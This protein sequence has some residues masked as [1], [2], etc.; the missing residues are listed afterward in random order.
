MLP[1]RE[2]FLG[3]FYNVIVCYGD[4]FF[5]SYNSLFGCDFS[6]AVIN[7]QVANRAGISIGIE[8]VRTIHDNIASND[9]PCLRNDTNDLGVNQCF[10][11]E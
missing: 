9:E 5:P 4:N 11:K 3:L 1:I 7:K 6:V 8:L 2:E 10:H